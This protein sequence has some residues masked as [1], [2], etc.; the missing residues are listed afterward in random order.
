MRRIAIVNRKG[1]VGKTTT[2]VNLAAAL[3]QLKKT[4]LVIDLDVQMNA[5]E[6]FGK[7]NDE[8]GIYEIVVERGE[9][10]KHIH[11]TDVQGVWIVPSS[12]H[13]ESAELELARKK[14][15]AAVTLDGQLQSL[16]NRFDYVLMDCPPNFGFMT[17]NALASAEEIFIPVEAHI[18]GIKGVIQLL[19]TFE[20]VK[21]TL[22]PDLEITGVLACRV[23]KQ[24]RHAQD[25][26]KA[27]KE[28]FKKTLFKTV[29]RQNVRLSECPGF[30][31][32]INE[33][34]PRSIGARDYRSLAKEVVK[35]ER[36]R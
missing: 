32:P 34:A 21:E 27:L 26:I 25:A 6:W 2:A 33:Y 20:R 30:Q 11:E 7:F 9:I 23:N 16:T 36:K 14:N 5:T 10:G 1:G 31:Q 13:L 18:L 3:G 22:N 15:G 17:A 24:T 29:I 28:Q 35:Q 12:S 4:V 19:D 8:K